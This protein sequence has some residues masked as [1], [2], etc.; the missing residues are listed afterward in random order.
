VAKLKLWLLPGQPTGEEVAELY[1]AITSVPEVCA[2]LPR[3]AIYDPDR[4]SF[5]DVDLNDPD[6]VEAWLDDPV[7]EKLAEDIG[8]QFRHEPVEVQR[9]ELKRIRSE[10]EEHRD[11]LGAALVRDD[12]T[13][14]HREV[15]Q[16]L[17]AVCDKYIDQINARLRELAREGDV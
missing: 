11:E 2:K 14:D 4:M 17:M 1:A 10:N 7:A 16:R 8:R 15:L 13:P 3:M 5:E 6:M 9:A 12:L